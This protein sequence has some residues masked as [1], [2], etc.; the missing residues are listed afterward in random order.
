MT[1][2]QIYLLAIIKSKQAF[3][4]Y[5][6]ETKKTNTNDKQTPTTEA[7]E[8]VASYVNTLPQNFPIKIPK[9]EKTTKK[10]IGNLFRFFGVFR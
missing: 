9:T 8:R 6:I 3:I 5:L 7:I 2:Y 10:V 4:K 1:M